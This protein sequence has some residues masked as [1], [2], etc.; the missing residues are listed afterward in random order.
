LAG[1]NLGKTK[2]CPIKDILL[3]LI[4]GV[5]ATNTAKDYNNYNYPNPPKAAAAATAAT[6]KAH[7]I[8]PQE[9]NDILYSL[10]YKVKHGFVIL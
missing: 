2:G 3:S 9:R 4:L 6:V 1:F 8:T 10:V 7:Y 5:A